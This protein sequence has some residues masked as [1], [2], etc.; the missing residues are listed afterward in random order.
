MLIY[1]ASFAD[2]VTKIPKVAI[3]LVGDIQPGAV[4]NDWQVCTLGVEG[5]LSC[6]SLGHLAKLRTQLTKR[7]RGAGDHLAR[8]T[9]LIGALKSPPPRKSR[10][11]M[12]GL[13]PSIP[14]QRFRYYRCLDKA[15]KASFHREGDES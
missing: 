15:N 2:R 12:F 3:A 14:V 13:M 11:W 6:R 5:V 7:P 10:T 1:L 4:H 8:M 9:E